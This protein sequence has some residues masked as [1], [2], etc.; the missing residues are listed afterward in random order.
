MFGK[1][2]GRYRIARSITPGKGK[3]EFP[4]ALVQESYFT[5]NTGLLYNTVFTFRHRI[6]ERF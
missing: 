3:F 4:I 2:G 1:S 6:R 5:C